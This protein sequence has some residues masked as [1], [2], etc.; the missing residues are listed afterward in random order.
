MF[1]AVKYGLLKQKTKAVDNQII[2]DT[3]LKAIGQKGKN[4]LLIN[5]YKTVFYE[6]ILHSQRE[7]C[8]IIGILSAKKHTNICLNKILFALLLLI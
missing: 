1:C 7:N 4:F 6:D 2:T 5:L 3:L 8:P